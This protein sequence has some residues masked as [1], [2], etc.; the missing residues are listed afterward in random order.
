MR[1]RS[2]KIQI[3]LEGA[4]VPF[5]KLPSPNNEGKFYVDERVAYMDKRQHIQ[6]PTRFHCCA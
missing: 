1:Q 2:L 6:N 4:K 3:G 5:L